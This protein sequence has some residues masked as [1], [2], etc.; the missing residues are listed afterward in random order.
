M[1][2]RLTTR[3]KN[4][5]QAASRRARKHA[6]APHWILYLVVGGL[7]TIYFWTPAVLR[8]TVGSLEWSLLAV[9]GWMACDHGRV[10]AEI[11]RSGESRNV[12]AVRT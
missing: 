2:M 11:A 10:N 3:V 12:K 4:R 5:L 8:D 7:V 1:A 9:L 6:G